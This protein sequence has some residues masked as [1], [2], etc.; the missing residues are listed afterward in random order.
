MA[1]FESQYME[2]QQTM[3][4][5]LGPSFGHEQWGEL[6][7]FYGA[8]CETPELRLWVIDMRQVTFLN[9]MLLGLLVGF[10]AVV[11]SRGQEFRLLVTKGSKPAEILY[12]AKLNRIINI[13]E[14]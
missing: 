6:Q 12:F 14:A 2:N 7:A 11:S 4:I 3:Q 9:S 10:N 5:V 13:R 8:Q 1:S